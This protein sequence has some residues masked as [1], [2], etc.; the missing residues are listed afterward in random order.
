MPGADPA[1]ELA[2][3]LSR[4][5]EVAGEMSSSTS[6][7]LDDHN[8]LH[9]HRHE[10]MGRFPWFDRSQF[11]NYKRHQRFFFDP[12]ST[13]FPSVILFMVFFTRFNIYETFHAGSFFSLSFALILIGM[14]GFVFFAFFHYAPLLIADRRHVVRRKAREWQRTWWG[15]Q[16]EDALGLV[17]TLQYGFCLYARVA[18]G[19]CP[20]MTDIWG[21]QKCNPSA[22]CRSIPE[23]QVIILLLIPLVLQ[24][25]VK[26]LSLVTI[27][28]CY[29]ASIGFVVASLYLVKGWNQWQS[30]AYILLFAFVSWESER[31]AR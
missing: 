2:P 26:G 11:A 24:H 15:S 5:A 23:D 22:V 18:A 19:Q 31:H 6:T 3:D 17:L 1:P 28:S 12:L 25:T 30:I 4:P 7:M 21:S 29:L 9:E 13:I 20:D 10:Y 27:V 14:I 8:Y 16:I